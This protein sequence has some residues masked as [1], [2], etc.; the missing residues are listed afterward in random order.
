ML[1]CALN[2]R[3]VSKL[4]KAHQYAQIVLRGWKMNPV[5]KEEHNISMESIISKPNLIS[6]STGTT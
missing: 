4:E 5:N 6:D 2:F 3:P 1:R